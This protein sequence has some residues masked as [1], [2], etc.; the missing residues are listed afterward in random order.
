MEKTE[1]DLARL[2]TNV[3]AI[4]T[5]ETANIPNDAMFK[6]NNTTVSCDL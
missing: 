4:V 3:E 2:V 1:S 5:V 6:T